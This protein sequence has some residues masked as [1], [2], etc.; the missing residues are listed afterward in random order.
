MK[1]IILVT[2]AFFLFWNHAG[3]TASGVTLRADFSTPSASAQQQDDGN[4]GAD[5]LKNSADSL[6]DAGVVSAEP[7]DLKSAWEQALA[8]NPSLKAVKERVQQAAER[9]NQVKSLFKPTLESD[10]SASRVWTAQN[11]LL[12]TPGM[13]IPEDYFA[14]EL[15]AQW[16]I[17]D[18]FSRKFTLAAA[19]HGEN[20]TRY[21]EKDTR[22]LLISAVASAYFN[23]QLQRANRAIAEADQAFNLQQLADATARYELGTGTLSDVL[24]FKVQANTAKSNVIFSRKEYQVALSALARLMGVAEGR[25]TPSVA[26]TQL[27]GEMPRELQVPKAAPLVGHALAHRPDLLALEAG[28]RQA[29]AGMHQAGSAWYPTLGV[30]ASVNARRSN[31]IHFESDDLAGSVAVGLNY[32]LFDGG[33]RRAKYQEAKSRT[34][35]ARAAYDDK[36]IAVRAEVHQALEA[37][38]M[39]RDQLLLQRTNAKLVKENRDLTALEYQAGQIS[40]VRLNEAQRDLIRAQSR[41]VLSLV[42][43]RRAWQDLNAAAMKNPLGS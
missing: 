22:R 43:L 11:T 16:L 25:F 14:P 41:L 35:E 19:R 26:L 15:T 4:A 1:Q 24:N 36:C 7:L 39:A 28:V 21:T 37:L 27:H 38:K 2:T 17:F 20:I 42:S 10:I 12:S 31:D 32:T 30:S 29:V 8:D 13:E 34:A 9:V 3:W 40:M 5:A 33:N 23:A 6:P 18:G